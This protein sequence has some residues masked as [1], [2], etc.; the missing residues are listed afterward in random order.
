MREGRSDFAAGFH[1]DRGEQPDLEIHYLVIGFGFVVGILV[2][3]TGMGGGSLMTPL[4]ILVLRVSPVV[5]VGT[6]LVQMT[7]TKAF[8]AWQHHRQGSVDYRLAFRLA[9]G[10]VPGAL[11]GVGFLALL[12][13]RGVAIDAV[14]SQALG[15]AL[16]LVAVLLLARMVLGRWRLFGT[17]A[18]AEG[19]SLEK[20][21]ALPAISFGVGVLVGVTS[22]GG[23]ALFV[24]VLV[25]MFPVMAMRRVVGT[26]VFHALMLTSV[27]GLA[28]WGA[29]H[30]DFILSANILIGSIPGVLIG[31]RLTAF[32][33]SRGLRAMVIATLFVVGLRML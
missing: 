25:S 33:P 10:S 7:V 28:H 22:V 14:V 23:G 12:E 8:G 21:R 27:A 6:D 18:G 15:V 11:A 31:S 1:G 30:V 24:V 16:L 29:G 13:R 5:A 9:V 4:L 26:D 17:G 3:L 20:S 2:G 32:I 19:F